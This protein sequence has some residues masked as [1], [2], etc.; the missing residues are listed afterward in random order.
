[1]KQLNQNSLLVFKE[2]TVY[3]GLLAD[4]YDTYLPLNQLSISPHGQ[5]ALLW[6]FEAK[7]SRQKGCFTNPAMLFGFKDIKFS[8]SGIV[9]IKRLS[10]K[11]SMG[12]LMNDFIT[13][14]VRKKTGLK[15]SPVHLNK[16]LPPTFP[17]SAFH[18]IQRHQRKNVL[19]IN[20]DQLRREFPIVW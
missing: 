16:N 17:K 18:F 10:T 20:P 13:Q 12:L 5:N 8:Q 19:V 3:F 1:M 2:E 9:F 4:E 7:Q 6:K 11:E 15:T 14:I